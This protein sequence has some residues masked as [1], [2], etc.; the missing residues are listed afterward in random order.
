M[1]ELKVYQCEICGENFKTEELA[2]AHEKM[3]QEK[4]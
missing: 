2:R 3:P 4:P 1:K